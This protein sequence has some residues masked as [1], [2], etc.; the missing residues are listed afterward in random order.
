MTLLNLT[1]FCIAKA[2]SCLKRYICKSNF[3]VCYH[4]LDIYKNPRKS[5][6][7]SSYPKHPKIITVTCVVITKLFLWAGFIII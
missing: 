7:K 3:Y 6:I 5:F 4:F 1:H 2:E